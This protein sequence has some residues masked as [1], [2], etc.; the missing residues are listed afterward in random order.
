MKKLIIAEKPSVSRELAKTLKGGTKNKDYFENQ[1][2]IITSLFGHILELYK[3]DDYNKEYKQWNIDDLPFFPEKFE[4]KLKNQK[5][6]KERY[7]LIEKLILRDDVDTIINCGD[8]DREGEVLVNNIIYYIFKKK[9]IEKHVKR[10]LLPDLAQATIKNE[11]EH[12]R[13]IK[14]TE[15]WYKEGLARTYVDWLYG[16]NFSRF[17]SIKT[18]ATFPVGRVIVPTVKFIYDREMEIKNFKEKKY[19]QIEGIIRKDNEEIKIEFAEKYE[20]EKEKQQ[21]VKNTVGKIIE[22]LQKHNTIVTNIEERES[23][24]KPKKLFSLKTIQNYMFSKYKINLSKTLEYAQTLYEKTY[25]TYPRTNSEYLTGEEKDKVEQIIKKINEKENIGLIMKDT[26]RIFDSSKVE[27]HSAIII[28]GNIPKTE[29]L[30][31]DESK[32]YNAIKNR[33]FANF[34]NEDCIIKEQMIKIQVEDT[35]YKYNLKGTTIKQQGYLKFENDLNEKAIPTFEEGEILNIKFNIVEKKTNPPT[36]VTEAELNNFYENPFKKQEQEET[37]D[38][39]YIAILKGAEIGTPATRAGIIEKVKQDGYITNSKNNL[40]ITDKG[41]KLIDVLNQLEINLYKEK[42]VEIGELLKNIFNNKKTIDDVLNKVK[43]EV[44][45]GIKKEKEIEIFANTKDTI[46][47][48]PICKGTLKENQKSY[49]CENW[50]EC[51]FSIWKQ[52]SGKKLS[53]SIIKELL[54]KGYTNK[55]KGFKSKS[56][57]NFDAILILEGNK[58]KFKFD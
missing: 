20:F 13:D 12:L 3:M 53:A 16:I 10:I 21:E 58:V 4:W 43:E 42:T 51:G 32:L 28:T 25:T 54:E 1:D 50:K 39:D 27:S 23:I 6:I 48:C 29:E 7:N 49:Y 18:S 35:D 33:F 46:S 36:R 37:T 31:E 57:K 9:K 17:V 47:Y 44:R 52:F 34:C 24:K 15:N 45:Q 19:F 5:G 26:K 8:N 38:E 41:I 56:G 22:E 40:V 2:Y 55:I 14:Q 11:L 30:T